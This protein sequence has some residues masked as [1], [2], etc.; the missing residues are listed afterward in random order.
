M[1]KGQKEQF[2]TIFDFIMKEAS[3]R[4]AEP[5]DVL[6]GLVATTGAL[7]KCFAETGVE[8]RDTMYRS[9]VDNLAK[10]VND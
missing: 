5:A 9:V 1:T 7:I 10:V 2:E 8:A 4:H 3:E 6:A